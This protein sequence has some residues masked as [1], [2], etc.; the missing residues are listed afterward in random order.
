MAFQKAMGG[1]LA[2]LLSVEVGCFIGHNHNPIC[3]AG[4]VAAK[5]KDANTAKS[6]FYEIGIDKKAIL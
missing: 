5:I 4:Q 2:G 1:F 6:R 3:G